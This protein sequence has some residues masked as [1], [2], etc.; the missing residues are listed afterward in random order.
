MSLVSSLESSSTVKFVVPRA[1]KMFKSNLSKEG[2][3]LA[4][5]LN[6]GYFETQTL[7]DM[8]EV[9]ATISDNEN[10]ILVGEIDKVKIPEQHSVIYRQR[11][12]FKSLKDLLDICKGIGIKIYFPDSFRIDTNHLMNVIEEL[13]ALERY[14][15]RYKETI[16]DW[17]THCL[18]ID[19]HYLLKAQNM[20]S[21]LESRVSDVLSDKEGYMNRAPFLIS[22][23]NIDKHFSAIFL[24]LMEEEGDTRLFTVRIDQNAKDLVYGYTD[25]NV[26]RDRKRGV[27]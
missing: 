15:Y 14:A 6:K 9:L 19:V 10:F 18:W 26:K 12:F 22:S 20:Y 13:P 11:L 4:F 21:D 23:Y 2:K 8:Q 25:D 27:L 24:H 16:D 1:G 5:C 7:E 17:L 3:A